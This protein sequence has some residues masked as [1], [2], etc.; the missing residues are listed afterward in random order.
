M[1]LLLCLCANNGFAKQLNIPL[2]GTGKYIVAGIELNAITPAHGQEWDGA[3]ALRLSR[4]RVK[5]RVVPTNW[6]GGY[7]R[8]QRDF[9]AMRWRSVLGV[10]FGHFMR[11]GASTD[12][13]FTITVYK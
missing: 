13:E 9:S 5:H 10:G 3:L 11:C 4:T 8:L 1:F 7:V 6:G 12:R 2:S